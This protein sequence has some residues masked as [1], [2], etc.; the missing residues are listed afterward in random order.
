MSEIKT[1]SGKDTVVINGKPFWEWGRAEH[2][3]WQAQTKT[4]MDVANSLY[5]R[6]FRWARTQGY[7]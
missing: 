3:I 1:V 4:M 7:L 5:V 2:K 6:L